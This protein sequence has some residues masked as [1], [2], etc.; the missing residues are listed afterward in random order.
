MTTINEHL[1]WYMVMLQVKTNIIISAAVVR[2]KR[3]CIQLSYSKTSPRKKGIPDLLLA[4]HVLAFESWSFLIKKKNAKVETS[5]Q[6][7]RTSAKQ[8]TVIRTIAGEKSISLTE[9]LVYLSTL[10]ATPNDI[11]GMYNY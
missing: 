7:C 11:I 3:A 2:I 5:K 9:F 4:S 1:I 8:T 10:Q 6:C